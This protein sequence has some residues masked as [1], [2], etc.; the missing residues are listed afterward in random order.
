MSICPI[1]NFLIFI[2]DMKLEDL[3]PIRGSFS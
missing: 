1:T 2:G 3:S